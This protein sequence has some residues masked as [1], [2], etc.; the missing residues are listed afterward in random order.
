MNLDRKRHEERSIESESIKI[1][2][3]T[4]VQTE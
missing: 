2:K 1:N 3:Q 4:D